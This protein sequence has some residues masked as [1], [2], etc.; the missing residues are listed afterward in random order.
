MAQEINNTLPFISYELGSTYTWTNPDNANQKGWALDQEIRAKIT[1]DTF[2]YC[3]IAL[4]AGIIQTDGGLGG[5]EII[6][7]SKNNGFCMDY[8][9]FPWN[10][11]RKTQR[12]GYISYKEL[13]N[14]GYATLSSGLIYLKYD[15]LS[16][17]NY[18]GFKAEMPSANW[19]QIS[20]QYGIGIRI[21]PFVNAY[22]QG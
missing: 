14:S 5:I 7:N 4:D 13:L 12:G 1:V 20:I 18:K 6:L 3:V 22:L 21:L 11:D 8:K 17:P 9:S 15:I 16:H 2:K 10:W 19:G